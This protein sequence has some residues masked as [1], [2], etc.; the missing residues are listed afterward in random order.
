MQE[1]VKSGTVWNTKTYQYLGIKIEGNLDKHINIIARKCDNICREINAIGA[2]NHVGKGDIVVNLKL[3]D[4]CLM[5]TLTNGME[6]WK[7]T[8]SMEKREIESTYE[9]RH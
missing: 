4:T 3:F 1:N 2:K 8:R 7:S 9:E 5:A 6:V